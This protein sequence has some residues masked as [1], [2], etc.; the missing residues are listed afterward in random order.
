MF[1][2]TIERSAHE[3]LS[4]V[5]PEHTPLTYQV[6]VSLS[7]SKRWASVRCSCGGSTIYQDGVTETFRELVES[8]WKGSQCAVSDALRLNSRVTA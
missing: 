4:P 8:A 5:S 1:G 6:Y 3:V 2:Y 7:V